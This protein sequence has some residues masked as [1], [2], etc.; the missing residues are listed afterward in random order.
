MNERKKTTCHD[1]IVIDKK[2][3]GKFAVVFI[4]NRNMCQL[5]DLA[6]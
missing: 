5:N 4:N 2:T 1:K 6:V 3:T